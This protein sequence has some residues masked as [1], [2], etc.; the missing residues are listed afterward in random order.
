LEEG[1]PKF[2]RELELAR[3]LKKRLSET[4]NEIEE[5]IAEFKDLEEEPE[6]E[7]DDDESENIQF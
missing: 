7:V 2:K 4:E 1:V 6:T 5:I 3:K